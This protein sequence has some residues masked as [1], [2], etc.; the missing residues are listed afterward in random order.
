MFKIKSYYQGCVIMSTK[1]SIIPLLSPV[2]LKLFFVI[3]YCLSLFFARCEAKILGDDFAKA[4]AGDFAV[5]AYQKQFTL[6]LVKEKREDALY[7][8]EISAPQGVLKEYQGKWQEWLNTQAPGHISWTIS[9]MDPKTFKI[10]SIF[11]P[12]DNSYKLPDETLTFL[13]TLLALELNDISTDDRKRSGP[14]PMAGELD[15]RKLWYPQIFYDGKQI[16]PLIEVKRVFW[17]ND[18]SDL[19]GKT[20][21][22]YIPQADAIEYFPYW[23]EIVAKFGK[24][25]VRVIDSGRA[26]KSL[27]AMPPQSLQT[28]ELPEKM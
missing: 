1:K 6:F 5:L 16:H 27:S 14:A 4:Q 23:V 19:S 20:I 18:G 15:F 7:L 10:L 12:E 3:C 25:K 11:C 9:K 17:P 21:D 2:L 8:E 13:P 22:L 24:V 28:K 26:L